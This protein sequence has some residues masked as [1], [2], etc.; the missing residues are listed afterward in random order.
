MT[1]SCPSQLEI[2]NALKCKMDVVDGFEQS[3]L[4]RADALVEELRQMVEAGGDQ[5]RAVEEAIKQ[6]AKELNV[7]PVVIFEMLGI[8]RDYKKVKKLKKGKLNPQEIQTIVDENI[9][10]CSDVSKCVVKM[11]VSAAKDPVGFGIKKAASCFRWASKIYQKA[12]CLPQPKVIFSYYR[13]YEG[14]DC[15]KKHAS[16]RQYAM[17]E[18]GDWIFYNNKNESDVTG[19]HSAV[20]LGW[21]DRGKKT[22]I[23]ASGSANTPWHIHERPIDFRKMPLTQLVKPI[24]KESV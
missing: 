15:G 24:P 1:E 11:A 6:T 14:K 12:G 17:V 13:A 8:G 5:K 4:E 22:A 2:V 3:S 18:P 16:E 21:V 19:N 10:D 7:E 23:V 9:E 20:F